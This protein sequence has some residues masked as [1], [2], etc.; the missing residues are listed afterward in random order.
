MAGRVGKSGL[1]GTL[2]AGGLV[3][4]CATV[5]TAT[6]MHD[7]PRVAAPAGWVDYC[8]RNSLDVSCR[9]GVTVVAFRG[10]ASSGN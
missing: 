10:D 7:G 2:L 5:P 6:A 8:Q 4:G 9:G 1:I 3:S